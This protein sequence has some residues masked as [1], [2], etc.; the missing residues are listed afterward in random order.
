M[1]KLNV[2]LE[3]CFGIGKLKHEF[4]FSD[5]NNKSNECN[6][7]AYMIYASNGT[8]K[9]SFAKTFELYGKKRK[10]GENK[11]KICDRVYTKRKPTYLIKVDDNKD[12][13]PDTIFVVNA[14]DNRDST[15]KISSFIAN[16]E[17]KEQYDEIMAYLDEE[18]K[19]ILKQ[20]K[21]IAISTD[22]EEEFVIAFKENDKDDFFTCIQKIV[23]QLEETPYDFTF[24]YNDVFDKKG[25][26]KEFVEKHKTLLQ[27]YC[28]IYNK[29]LSNSCFFK[30]N[31]NGKSFGTYQAGQ[32][33]K[34]VGDD[35]FFDAGHKFVLRKNGQNDNTK[36]EKSKDLVDLIN[37]EKDKIFKDKEL[38]D[39][40]D[41]IDK[42]ISA[43]EELR[44]FKDVL[45]KNRE[46]LLNKLQNYDNFE[47][48]VLI[49][50]FS[51][52]KK[53]I[54]KL[55]SSY[56]TKKEEL[57]KIIEEAKKQTDTWKEIVDTFNARFYVPFSVKIKNQDDIILKDKA[58]PNIYFE[59]NDD[60]IQ[61]NSVYEENKDKLLKILSKGEQRAYHILQM[62]FEI[63]ARKKQGQETLIIF[64]DI[65]D[66]FD[67]KNKYAIIEY[68]KD[69]LEYTDESK[70]KLFK[71]IIL[72]H[73]FDFY[74][75]VRLRLN[76]KRNNC[77]IATKK[78]SDRIIE[79]S[80]F[81]YLSDDPIYHILNSLEKKKIKKI[82]FI[83]LIPFTRNIIKYRREYQKENDIK[84]KYSKLTSCLHIKKDKPLSKEI[85]NIIREEL[86]KF[87]D[88]TIDF[89]NKKIID[90][91]KETADEIIKE[92]TNIDKIDLKNK[93]VLSIAIRLLAEE[94]MMGKIKVDKEFGKQ[95]TYELFKC[96][97]EKFKD[98]KIRT[99]EKVIMMTPE[100]IHIN[101]FMY[102]PLI[103][104]SIL[105]L[106]ELYRQIKGLVAPKKTIQN[107]NSTEN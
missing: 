65:A 56:Q 24:K 98:D 13:Q 53:D 84:N 48:E 18:K 21:K 43:N 95:Q 69:L 44:N 101:A 32:I 5:N 92:D 78:C 40:F 46:L 22:C 81:N 75:T 58:V 16:K 28:E 25:K 47:K 33:Q 11:E 74:R 90:L 49:S 3:N 99:L 50:Y 37:K 100:N 67:Y 7:N 42:S 64:D 6:N 30:N 4:N 61:G 93:I 60:G 23:N 20:L 52:L 88:A 36:I 10:D 8:M 83:F 87:K 66:S 9:S 80:E 76:I 12:I 71:I 19:G 59:Y 102:E 38:K 17:L 91:I 97:K 55:N 94:F 68:I 2:T 45:E 103:D 104:M 62:I 39:A 54:E 86:E 96:Y 41:K 14:E 106:R 26:V 89:E 79:L 63:E 57:Q 73:N 105:H 70:H 72:T 77:L 31:S 51:K 82:D 34:A 35:T 1:D 85:L 15:A 107:A 29:L 27:N